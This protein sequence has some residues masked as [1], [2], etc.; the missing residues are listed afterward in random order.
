MDNFVNAGET[1][2]ITAGATI[3][4]GDIVVTNNVVGIAFE[5]IANTEKGNVAIEG[6]YRLPKNTSTAINEG[7][8]VDF[9]VSVPEVSTGIT[10]AAGD[11]EDFGVAMETVASAGAFINVKLLPGAGTFA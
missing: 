4:A 11:V 2:E 8:L 1:M 6:V 3:S 9:D 7:D 10:P 5:D